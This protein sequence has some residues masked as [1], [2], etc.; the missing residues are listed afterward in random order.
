VSILGFSAAVVSKFISSVP[1]DW[2]VSNRRNPAAAEAVAARPVAG[3][4]QPRK[5][6]AACFR[7]D[8]FDPGEHV[9]CICVKAGEKVRLR[10]TEITRGA[11]VLTLSNGVRVALSGVSVMPQAPEKLIHIVYE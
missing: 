4:E 10:R 5:A 3:A 1:L 7:V 2:M 6:A 9:V 11:C 8:G